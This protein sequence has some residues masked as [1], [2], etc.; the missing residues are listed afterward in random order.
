MR[1]AVTVIAEQLAQWETRPSISTL[2]GWVS[3]DR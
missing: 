2:N 1:D 3:S